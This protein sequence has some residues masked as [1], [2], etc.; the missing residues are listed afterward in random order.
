MR[1]GAFILLICCLPAVLPVKLVAEDVTVQALTSKIRVMQ[2]KRNKDRAAA[3]RLSQLQL[4]ERLTWDHK[5]ELYKILP[6]EKSRHALQ[7]LQDASEFLSPPASEL[8]TSPIPS[9]VE[10]RKMLGATR[11][12]VGENYAHLPNFFATRQLERYRMEEPSIKN[13]FNQLV[14][15]D[16]LSIDI[17]VRD[18]KETDILA[19]IDNKK[20][21][22][23]INRGSIY[24]SGEFA[25][26]LPLLFNTHVAT[27]FR[28]ARWEMQAG[29]ITAVFSYTVDKAHSPFNAEYCCVPNG[30]G[31]S[32]HYLAS[33][34]YHGEIWINLT[35]SE[36]MRV[37]SINDEAPESPTKEWRSMVEFGK[38]KVGENQ[39]QLPVRSVTLVDK[40]VMDQF[41][42]PVEPGRVAT[43]MT[44]STF[45]NYHLFKSSIRFPDEF[46]EPNEPAAIPPRAARPETT[47]PQPDPLNAPPP[48]NPKK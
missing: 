35:T 26:M 39:Y 9:I 30:H 45:V 33:P 25:A 4:T 44:E 29:E 43:L 46:P 34:A 20:M 19:E 1:A 2:S 22:D 17:A 41:L 15:E 18:G 10:Q 3:G 8:P 32:K 6:G 7:L 36:V 37:T 12:L 40:K 13:F 38:I 27:S 16:S 28:W 42:I 31:G 23:L 47:P 14:H 11:T 24:S 21:V 48:V 5:L